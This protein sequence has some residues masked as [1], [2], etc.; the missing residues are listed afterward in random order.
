MFQATKTDGH[1]YPVSLFLKKHPDDA[2]LEKQLNLFGLS[3]GGSN[4]LCLGMADTVKMDYDKVPMSL[5]GKDRG[6]CAEA[7]ADSDTLTL[8]INMSQGP[9]GKSQFFSPDFLTKRCEPADRHNTGD[10]RSSATPDLCVG[11]NKLGDNF[12]FVDK[13]GYWWQ[14]LWCCT[15]I[16][17]QNP[18]NVCSN[19]AIPV[20]VA[21][22]Q[23]W[24]TGLP[25]FFPQTN[26]CYR[27]TDDC[28]AACDDYSMN[29][30]GDDE[31]QKQWS[32][33]V[34]GSFCQHF[35][36]QKIDTLCAR[37]FPQ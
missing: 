11:S 33:Y 29:F 32:K 27:T 15:N 8:T 28:C 25:V 10:Y 13:N 17:D 37:P 22:G 31:L 35:P 16:S 3:A 30:D 20:S 2:V 5:H 4:C 34:D 6:Y 36:V 12:T 7:Q 21:I 24:K 14:G 1:F 9:W 26:T 19:G 23:N 18:E